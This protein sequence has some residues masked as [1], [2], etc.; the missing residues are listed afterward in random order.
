MSATYQLPAAYL[1]VR[2]QLSDAGYG[3]QAMTTP[4][5]VRDTLRQV[6]IDAEQLERL[7]RNLLSELDEADEDA[8]Q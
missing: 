6:Q 4:A 1:R 3:D 5:E 2:E 7:Y 8:T